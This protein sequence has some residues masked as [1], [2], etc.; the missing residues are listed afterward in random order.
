MKNTVLSKIVL[1][2]TNFYTSTWF[3]GLINSKIWK[4]IQIL[5]CYD[6]FHQKE[7]FLDFW[8]MQYGRQSENIIFQYFFV[9]KIHKKSGIW[10]MCSYNTPQFRER[11][12]LGRKIG[13]GSF[14]CSFMWFRT[15][16]RPEKALKSAIFLKKLGWVI[17]KT[18]RPWQNWVSFLESVTSN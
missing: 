5:M 7:A 8:K 16:S 2:V 10:C 6:N 14:A 18:G 17:E 3:A 4:T 12:W 9:E 13:L 15:T 1:V 11:C